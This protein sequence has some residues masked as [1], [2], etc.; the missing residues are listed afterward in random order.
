MG[1]EHI[2]GTIKQI[3][4]QATTKVRRT[5]PWQDTAVR[6]AKDLGIKPDP[7][8]FRFFKNAFNSGKEGLLE[9]AFTYVI[10]AMFPN[11]KMLFFWYY[12]RHLKGKSTAVGRGA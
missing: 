6:M 9:S 10:D 5:L 7:N 2:S 3:K 1:L 12:Y 11:P 8:W 4:I